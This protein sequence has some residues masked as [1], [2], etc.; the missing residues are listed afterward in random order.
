[1][2]ARAALLAVALVGGIMGPLLPVT[3]TRGRR[4]CMRLHLIALVL[5]ALGTPV[6]A[7]WLNHPTSGLPRGADGKPNLTA[8]TPRTTDGTPDFSGVWTGPAQAPRLQ[9]STCSHGSS[10]PDA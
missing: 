4:L 9:L 6:G 8:P 10:K 7:Q 1:R 2:Q 3:L 5:V